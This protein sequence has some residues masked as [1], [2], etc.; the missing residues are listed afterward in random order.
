MLRKKVFYPVREKLAQLRIAYRAWLWLSDTL[1][2]FFAQTLVFGRVGLR[3]GK[4]R[5]LS[6]NEIVQIA[7]C[8][9]KLQVKA[10]ERH[11][12]ARKNNN[13]IVETDGDSIRRSL[14]FHLPEKLACL[15]I[16]AVDFVIVVAH[17]DSIVMHEWNRVAATR[18]RE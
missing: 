2:L 18:H 8:L 10:V 15:G 3:H 11:V 12:H 1:S 16:Q 5:S 13:R 4:K 14:D 7:S 17:Y 9:D 6:A